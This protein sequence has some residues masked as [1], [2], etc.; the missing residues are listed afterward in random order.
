M[1]G[2]GYVWSGQEAC[3]DGN[4]TTCDGC[5]SGTCSGGDGV[6]Q[7]VRM[8]GVET[9]DDGNGDNTDGCPDGVG[10]TC[11][12]AV[13]GDGFVWSGQEGCDD[14]GRQHDDCPD[15]LRR[16]GLSGSCGVDMRAATTAMET[17]RTNVRMELVARARW[18]CAVTGSCGVDMRAATTATETTRTSCL[19][20]RASR[21]AAW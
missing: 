3:D 2:D 16:G 18:R 6:R 19:G 8:C 21:R 10:G 20:W 14:D 7:R 4:P 1:C 5:S 17:T 15:G 12:N 13:C 9:C 11:Q